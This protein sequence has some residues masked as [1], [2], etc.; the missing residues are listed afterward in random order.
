MSVYSASR[1]VYYTT[2]IASYVP[3]ITGVMLSIK[4]ASLRSYIAY[5]DST[6]A[7]AGA[8]CQGFCTRV[9]HLLLVYPKGSHQPVTV[10]YLVYNRSVYQDISR[11][12]Q[13]RLCI[14]SSST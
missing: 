10:G 9:F 1:Q 5:I 2:S 11:Q 8:V 3:A 14:H 4:R 6:C 7:T 13:S 12:V